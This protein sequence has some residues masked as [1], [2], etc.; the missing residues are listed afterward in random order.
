MLAKQ[1]QEALANIT[2][3]NRSIP[4]VEGFHKRAFSGS[5]IQIKKLLKLAR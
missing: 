2:L 4:P 1:T 3:M 5:Y